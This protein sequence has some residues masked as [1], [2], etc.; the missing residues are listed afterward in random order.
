ML[1]EVSGYEEKTFQWRTRSF[2]MI[3]IPRVLRNSCFDLTTDA[4]SHRAWFG[5]SEIT[6][7]TSEESIW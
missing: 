6:L 1:S 2:A 7:Q 3:S 4:N 5:Y